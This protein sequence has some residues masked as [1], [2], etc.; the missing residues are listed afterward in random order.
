MCRC[1]KR[2]L[3]ALLLTLA[4][5][6]G[7]ISTTPDRMALVGDTRAGADPMILIGEGR[8]AT[9]PEARLEAMGE[10]AEQ[11]QVRIKVHHFREWL[12]TNG[13]VDR[14]DGRTTSATR[15]ALLEGAQVVDRAQD[16]DSCWRKVEL[17]LR[18]ADQILA[19]RLRER[20]GGG[21]KNI[22]LEGPS[23]L[24]SSEF[25]TALK[26]RLDA[27][28]AGVDAPQSV[29]LDLRHTG[30]WVLTASDEAQLM[31]VRNLGRLLDTGLLT[32]KVLV[33][34]NRAAGGSARRVDEGERFRVEVVGRDVHCALFNLYQ[35]G[36]V[37]LLQ[38]SSPLQTTIR[39]P[40]GEA[41][42]DACPVGGVTTTDLYVAVCSQAPIDT[43]DF[44]VLP[45]A[46]LVRQEAL[47]LD[48]FFRWLDEV[49]G[50]QVAATPMTVTPT[51]ELTACTQSRAEN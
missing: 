42:Y 25:A 44:V 19:Q 32:E 26:K 5:C 43:D 49:P 15:D 39:L 51:S 6:G 27:P 21:S 34:V 47:H 18:P 30:T 48:L 46:G 2:L 9:C 38:A 24:V 50:R 17:N 11:V 36:R 13:R 29:T 45:A 33:Q 22:S 7:V 10:L 31:S 35:D 3:G 20:W 14:S 40:G 37:A 1:D 4:G 28:S 12:F 41:T 16:E 23:W 8:A